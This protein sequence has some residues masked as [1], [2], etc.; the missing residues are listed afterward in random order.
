MF[1]NTFNILCSLPWIQGHAS[2]DGKP[3]L[4]S[5]SISIPTRAR[6]FTGPSVLIGIVQLL[7]H[8]CHF[9][10]ACME[11]EQVSLS[12]YYFV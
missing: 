2:E 9:V 3:P 6:G 10:I 11:T 5:K 8:V 12:F 1:G 4:P 7:S